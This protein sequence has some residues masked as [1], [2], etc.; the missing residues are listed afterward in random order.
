LKWKRKLSTRRSNRERESFRNG[1]GGRRMRRREL[2]AR[3][4]ES[5][6]FSN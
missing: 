1:F 3:E 4:N 5:G 6:G 2:G